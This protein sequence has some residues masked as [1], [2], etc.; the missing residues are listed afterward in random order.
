M[1]K[2]NDDVVPTSTLLL[3]CCNEGEAGPYEKYDSCDSQF[4]VATSFSASLRNSR[5][6]FR[7]FEVD[8]CYLYSPV[9][10]ARAVPSEAWEKTYNMH[11]CRDTMVSLD[12]FSWRLRTAVSSGGSFFPC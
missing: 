9:M 10:P 3:L 5:I 8:S 4:P 2:L 12:L 7:V 1:S 11:C 6:H